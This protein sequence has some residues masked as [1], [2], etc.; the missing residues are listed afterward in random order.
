MATFAPRP[1][2]FNKSSP[3]NGSGGHSPAS[4]ALSWN[5]S[6][7]ATSYKYCVD[8]IKN[9]SC[10][11]SWVPVGTNLSTTLVLLKGSTTYYWQ[12]RAVNSAGSTDANAGTW[13]SFKTTNS[14][15]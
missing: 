4:L 1:H 14:T 7:G 2:A 12:V 5:A 13:W 6:S 11:T 15:K 3:T 10:D 9:N 8:T